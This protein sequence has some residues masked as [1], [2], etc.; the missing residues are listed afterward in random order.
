VQLGLARLHVAAGRN[1]ADKIT[2]VISQNYGTG[3]FVV[4]STMMRGNYWQL[5][6]QPED[7]SEE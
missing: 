1:D 2:I 6:P 4:D 7:S 3:A 5:V